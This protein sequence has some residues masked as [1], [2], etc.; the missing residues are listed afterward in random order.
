MNLI[1]PKTVTV[2]G[3]DG[4]E[5]EFTIAK[6][7]ARTGRRV[8]TQYLPSALPKV[9]NYETNEELALT[10]LS[11][12]HVKG[13]SENLIPLSTWAL[14]NN[15][16]DDWQMQMKL[17]YE[18]FEYNTNFLGSGKVSTVL[19]EFNE[20]LPQLATKIL[21]DFWVQLSQKEKQP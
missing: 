12:A 17:E 8:I 13:P 21:T 3:I 9:G 4:Q 2:S 5:K 1:Q 19:S 7:P 15:H 20:K 14:V 10:L 11:Y 16:C 6:M 18:V